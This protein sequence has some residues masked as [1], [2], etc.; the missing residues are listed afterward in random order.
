MVAFA[1][2]RCEREADA[3]RKPVAQRAGACLDAG[4]DHLG[5]A[6][7]DRIE[8]AEPVEFGDREIAL[9]GEH[10]IE[11]EAAVPFDQDEAVAARPFWLGRPMPQNIVVEHADYFHDRERGSDVAALALVDRL[12]ISR[13]R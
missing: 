2:A 1:H 8:M 4:R 6:A 10:C 13:R 7:E 9:V 5:M 12:K 11:R 3:D